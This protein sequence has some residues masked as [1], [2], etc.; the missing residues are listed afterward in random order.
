MTLRDIE[1][2]L[3]FEAYGV[4]DAG[5]VNDDKIKRAKLLSE[6]DYLAKIEEHGDDF[7]ATMGAEG[8]RELLRAINLNEQ[9]D[10]LRKELE[11]TG[12]DTKIKRSE[13][14]RVGKECRSRWS[15]YH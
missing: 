12:S 3:Y 15:P 6:E 7:S 2:V 1:R 5:M 13:E 14:R 4:T 9:I 8:I 10:T 11:S